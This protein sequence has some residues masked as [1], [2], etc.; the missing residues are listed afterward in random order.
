MWPYN[1]DEALWLTLDAAVGVATLD[2][3]GETAN[4]NRPLRP[5]GDG[6]VQPAPVLPSLILRGRRRLGL[7]PTAQHSDGDVT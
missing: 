6:S 4:D 3:A 1:E 2:R 5:S 7:V